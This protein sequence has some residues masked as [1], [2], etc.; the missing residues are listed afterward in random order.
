MSESATKTKWV[1][2]LIAKIGNESVRSALKQ[3]SM[4]TNDMG[5]ANIAQYIIDLEKKA[6]VHGCE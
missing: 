4:H 6:G 2:A 5:I 3:A 1:T